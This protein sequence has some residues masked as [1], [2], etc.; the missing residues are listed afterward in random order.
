[1]SQLH[2]TGFNLIEGPPLYFLGMPMYS[3]GPRLTREQAE[4]L[5]DY[6]EKVSNYSENTALASLVFAPEASPIFGYVAV[7]AKQLQHDIKPEPVKQTLESGLDLIAESL[8]QSE[9]W[10]LA[11]AILSLAFGSRPVY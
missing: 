9:S 8:D 6:F 2:S 7:C 4:A 3:T 1:M 10:T 11:K 5:A